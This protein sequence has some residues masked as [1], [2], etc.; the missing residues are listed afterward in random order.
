M[1]DTRRGRTF[2]SERTIFRDS[3]T[4]CLAWRMTC[5]P[6]VDVNDYYDIP[7]WNAD[8]SV[9][10]FLSRRTGDKIRWLMD[11]NGA[12]L[13]PMPTA[14]GRSIGSGY[15][16]VLYPDR[17]YHA[18]FDGQETRVLAT[19]PLTGVQQT[20]V[21]V[22]GNLGEMM[23]PHPTEKWFLFGRQT[24]GNEDFNAPSSAFVVGLDGSVRE[25][26]FER[27]WHRLRFTKSPDGR[28]FFN[29]DE[30]RT[31][32][33]IL[34]DGSDKTSIPDPG[35]HPDWLAGGME[36]TYY[37]GGSIWAVR[38]D[39]TGKRLVINLGSGGHG[40]PTLDG[41]WFVSDTGRAGNFPDS[42][43]YL[44]TDGSETCHTLFKH[45]SSLYAHTTQWHPDH[46]SSHPHPTSSPDGTKTLFN[47]DFLTEFTD[48]YIAVN[49]LPEPPQNVSARIEG[50]K[51]LLSWERPQRG[52]EIRGYHIYKTSTS[53]FNYRR[54]N[55]A[56]ITSTKITDSLDADPA[57]YVVT[58]V[59]YS[60]LESRPSAEV[61]QRGNAAWEGPARI[62]VEAETGSTALPMEERIGQPDASNLYCVASRE[63]KAGGSLILNVAVPKAAKYVLWARV[64]GDGAL[65][66]S[67]N[68]TPAGKVPCSASQ[69]AW[70]KSETVFSLSSGRHALK[71]Q[72]ETGRESVDKIL[73]TDDSN[74]VPKGL[75]A[76][77]E[78]PPPAPTNI[79]AKACG[80]NSVVLSWHSTDSADVSY[81]NVYAAP[82]AD[83]T[84]TQAQRVGSPPE[85]EFVDWGLPLNS[86]YFYRVTAV[87]CAGNESAPS[88]AVQ[89]ALQHFEVAQIE[90]KPESAKVQNMS[91]VARP[92]AGGRVLQ[93][94]PSNPS[95]AEWEFEV[96][97]DG[98]YAIWGRA[99][100]EPN[101]RAVFNLALDGKPVGTWQV[102]GQW[103][104]W[105]WSAVG[106]RTA[107]SPQTFQLSAGKHTLR[108]QPQKANAPVAAI[109][110]TNDPTWWPV[111]FAAHSLRKQ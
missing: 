4:G 56:L 25:V 15:W 80:P 111:K 104:Q 108:L 73:L 95:S 64:K 70:Q 34:P 79:Q 36:L 22:R 84:C 94:A 90:L 105:V 38:Y 18:A 109:V 62:A 46:H 66:A 10:G 92:A 30:P 19:N 12:N 82:R 55:P 3:K 13:R 69:W 100:H 23:P 40:G 14:D 89:V 37:S 102:R 103:Q 20:I 16:S 41:D 1:T 33:T 9:M 42:I 101:R 88:P 43:L 81:F 110:I 71:L 75:L 97:S 52:R 21:R 99:M 78:T 91:V 72:A 87:D 74:F 2:L 96:P 76:V 35:S 85:R 98:E 86:T 48:I 54:L 106:N 57:Y 107:G 51:V 17:F 67:C 28:I 29:F 31:Q 60:G 58:A 24:S 77:D 6:A 44:R 49:R 32:W 27:R 63:G 8:G 93:P 7:G 83:F 5:D 11:A 50:D 26:K 39:G 65:A 59:E 45:G 53:G 61:F 47:S 68:G